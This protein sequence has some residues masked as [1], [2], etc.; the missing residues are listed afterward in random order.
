MA[1]QIEGRSRSVRER[2]SAKKS[3]TVSTGGSLL[4]WGQHAVRSVQQLPGQPTCQNRT[5]AARSTSLQREL[6]PQNGRRGGL[7]TLPD[8]VFVKEKLTDVAGADAVIV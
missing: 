6:A 5:A 1:I 8:A 2:A 4:W 7:G 3:G